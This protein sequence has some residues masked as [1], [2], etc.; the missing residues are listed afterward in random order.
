MYITSRCIIFALFFWLGN[1]IA[2]TVLY[3]FGQ[4]VANFVT[5]RLSMDQSSGDAESDI[6]ADIEA[7]LC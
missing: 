7:M 2:A 5:S 6:A 3:R 1:V 4:T